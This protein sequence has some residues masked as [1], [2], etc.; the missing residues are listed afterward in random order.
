VNLDELERRV[1]VCY[2]GKPRRT[3]QQL[4]SLQGAHRGK[5]AVQ[6]SLER[7]SDVAQK[8]AWLSKSPTGP[9]GPPLMRENGPFEKRNLPP[10]RRRPLIASSKT[11]AERRA[12]RQVCGAGGG[13]VS[14]AHRAGTPGTVERPLPKLAARSTHDH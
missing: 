5:L 9:S 1:V 12:G 14:S 4:G 11:H 7:I 3:H 6:N 10:S 13:D 2:T 8:C